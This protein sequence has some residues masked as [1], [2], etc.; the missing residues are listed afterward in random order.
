[1]SGLPVVS[2]DQ[3]KMESRPLYHAL[4]SSNI[5]WDNHPG[6]GAETQDERESK[7][8]LDQKRQPDT[9]HGVGKVWREVFDLEVLGWHEKHPGFVFAETMSEVIRLQQGSWHGEGDKRPTFKGVRV[10]VAE[11]G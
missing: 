3:E 7:K 9:I 11:D 10:L 4:H 6:D 2:Q 1:M 8:R 5:D